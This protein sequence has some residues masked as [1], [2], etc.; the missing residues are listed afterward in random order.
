MGSQAGMI[1]MTGTVGSSGTYLVSGIPVDVQVHSVLKI[2]FEN[3]T[4]ATF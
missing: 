3:N 1:T 4:S 2:L